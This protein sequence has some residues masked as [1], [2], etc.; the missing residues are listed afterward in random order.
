MDVLDDVEPVVEFD[1][2]E[3]SDRPINGDRDRDDRDR[4]QQAVRPP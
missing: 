2:R 3:T 4:G 1:E